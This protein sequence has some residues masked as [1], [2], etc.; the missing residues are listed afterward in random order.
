MYPSKDKLIKGQV[1]AGTSTDLGQGPCL[2]NI[3]G[4][5]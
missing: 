1:T 4:L 3:K 2:Q 5:E